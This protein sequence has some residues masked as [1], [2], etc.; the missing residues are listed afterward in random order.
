MRYIYD[1]FDNY[2]GHTSLPVKL[3]AH[4]IRPYLQW[5]DMKSNANV[6]S[7]IANSNFVR[8]RITQYYQ[9][10]SQVIFPF[11]DLKDFRLIQGSLPEKKNFFLMVTAFAPNKKVD[12]AIEAFNELGHEYQLKIIGQGSNEETE[13]LFKMAKKNTEFLGNLPRT[14]VI[15]Y[16]SEA[17]ALIF[18]GVED[19]GI[20]PLESLAAGTPVIAYKTAG[21][22]DT[23]TD[24]T[25][26]FFTKP[27]ST[28]LVQAIKEF[29]KRQFHPADLFNRAEYF[30]KENFVNSF[31]KKCTQ[32]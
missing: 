22:L 31:L 27:N 16:F 1:Q 11:V 23:L 26:H 13:R 5:W 4:L 32:P 15:K 30:S 8:Q 18:P 7:F 6:D 12:L 14:D 9:V 29:Q 17:Q 3:V 10:E 25:A 24:K 19:F 28:A 20:T 2:F 21:V